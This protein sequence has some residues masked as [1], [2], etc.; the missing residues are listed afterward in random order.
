VAATD[1]LGDFESRKVDIRDILPAEFVGRSHVATVMEVARINN[2]LQDHLVGA[3]EACLDSQDDL[4][5]L[6][7]LNFL[8]YLHARFL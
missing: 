1:V 2:G 5:Q 3:M 4:A 8:G 7:S 6:H